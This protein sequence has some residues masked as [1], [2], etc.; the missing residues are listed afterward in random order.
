MNK[1]FISSY[2]VKKLSTI[3]TIKKFVKNNIN[4]IELS[5]NEYINKKEI[6]KIADNILQLGVRLRNEADAKVLLCVVYLCEN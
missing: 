4:N 2:G 6:K 1:V 3:K 5:S